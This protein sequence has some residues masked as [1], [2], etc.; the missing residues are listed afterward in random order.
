M[1]IE[2]GDAQDTATPV[3]P[4]RT[5]HLSDAASS[6]LVLDS[7]LRVPW[8]LALLCQE[9]LEDDGTREQ[10]LRA[11]VPPWLDPDDLET[12]VDIVHQAKLPPAT[13]LRLR[14]KAHGRAGSSGYSLTANWLGGGG[15]PL[16]ERVDVQG[17]LVYFGPQARRLTLGQHLVLQGIANLPPLGARRDDDLRETARIQALIPAEDE[18]VVLDAFL[19]KER[20]VSVS[21]LAPRLVSVPGGFQVRPHADGVP[22]AELDQ[23]YYS[24]KTGERIL[25]IA[26]PD[27][28]RTRVVFDG[29]ASAGFKRSRE[30]NVLTPE[31]VAE[32]VERP[33][34]VFGTSFDLSAASERVTGL[35]VPV[36]QAIPIVKELPSTA[37]WDWDVTAEQIDLESGEP[38]GPPLSF[39]DEDTRIELGEAIARADAAG[40]SYVPAPDGRSL[41][42]ITPQ[43]RKAV[44]AAT[45]LAEAQDPV[46]KKVSTS[47]KRVLLVKENLESLGF[48]S[49]HAGLRPDLAAQLQQPAGLKS[50]FALKDHQIEGFRWL[51]TVFGGEDTG[52]WRGGML[53]DDMGLGKTLQVLS[54][55]SWL[56][57]N[58]RPG[59][60]LVVAPVGLLD[61]WQREA[62]QF[63]G[64]RFEPSME[65]EGRHLPQELD[66]VAARLGSQRIVYTSYETLRRHERKFASVRWDMM[67]LDEAQKAKVPT[68]QISRVVRAI[69]ARGRLAMTGTP[70]ENTLTEL[71]TLFDWAVPGLLG[72]LREF[73]TDTIK[74]LR[75]A[76]PEEVQRIAAEIHRRI[77]PVF[78]R[79][80][81]EEILRDLPEKRFVPN[82]VP[83]SEKQRNTYASIL[84]QDRKPKDALGVLIRLF[85]V[86]AHPSLSSN[87]TLP[88]PEEEAFPKI[89]RVFGL[90]DR[91]RSAGEKVIVFANRKPIQRWLANAF[92]SRY[93]ILVDIINGDVSE[94]RTR[95][96][97]IDR[98]TNTEGFA[99]LVLAPRAAGVGLN[100]TA[101][102]HVIHYMREWNPAVENQATDRAYRIGQTKPVNVYTLIGTAPEGTTVEEKLD[103][104]LETKRELMRQFVV[105]MGLTQVTEEELLG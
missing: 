60:H 100:I 27:G 79:R 25:P 81:K 73:G 14:L 21:K 84:S 58:G 32:A 91:I 7:T 20:V 94:S 24:G 11:R 6:H 45:K 36:R 31:Q 80:M 41:L 68:A 2:I 12:L 83:L 42:E 93:G 98:F 10:S 50:P 99:V 59:P 66:R 72:T 85:A 67:I 40:R 43:L 105:P 82:R 1:K 88:T 87:A 35:G 63:F 52:R 70:V 30:L 13:P 86:C 89:E 69:G 96:H 51:V 101:A 62:N 76:G 3:S 71:W 104:L 22:D 33:E 15:K 65:V 38:A 4:A 29:D 37:W 95:M 74:P 103:A 46:S 23:Y 97:M 48:A 54:L 90:L 9:I 53:A 26:G 44:E 28:A 56:I 77:E 78:I 49:E 5:P 34:E 47:D 92:E 8:G 19:A 61:N 17:G 18:G 16:R 57:E 102:N 39:K 75:A 55:L 64:A